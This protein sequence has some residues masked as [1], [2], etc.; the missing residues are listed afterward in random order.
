M[1]KEEKFILS[2]SKAGMEENGEL[3]V[4]PFYKRGDE[5]DDNI[6]F[7]EEMYKK[8]HRF[9]YLVKVKKEWFKKEIQKDRVTSI[10]EFVRNKS[11]V[12]MG[13]LINLLR[14]ERRIGRDVV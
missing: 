7:A 8:V 3:V 9:I 12:E 6:E 10:L 5:I 11:K 13:C 1:N 4:N 14:L 2:G